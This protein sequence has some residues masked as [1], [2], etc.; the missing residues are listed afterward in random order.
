[1]IAILVGLG[2]VALSGYIWLTRGFF[3]A[4]IHLVCT[5]I[6]GAIAFALWEPI[7][8]A[9]LNSQS[10]SYGMVSSMAW[11]VSLLLPFLAS[12]AILRLVVDNILKWNVKVPQAV[13]YIGGG[14]C[15]A[16]AGA[17]IAGM[18][19]LSVGFL[20]VEREFMATPVGLE[21]SQS[22]GLE[23]KG[24][25]AIVD[26]F[27]VKFYSLLSRGA[28][29]TDT[30]LADLAP[31]LESL[32]TAM[33]MTDGDGKNSNAVKESEV[34]IKHRYT[35]D[36]KGKAKLDEIMSDKWR[37][38]ANLGPQRASDLSGNPYP[39]TSRI[40][41]FVVELG[42]GAV[43]KF[44]QI[45]ISNPQ[46]WLVCTTPDG[47][48]ERLHP[49]AVASAAQAVGTG[50]R[51]RF[52][53][54]HFDSKAGLHLASVGGGTSNPMA[55]EFLVPQG[56]E[57]RFVSVRNIRVDISGLKPVVF[58]SVAERDESIEAGTIFTGGQSVGGTID[59]ASLD[60]SQKITIG[61][62]RPLQPGQNVQIEGVQVTNTLGFTIQK[63]THGGL[64]LT[65]DN[66]IRGGRQNFAPDAFQQSGIIDRKLRVERFGGS[67]DAGIIQLDVSAT[68][69][70]NLLLRSV[71]NVETGEDRP[72]LVDS[73][74]R[75]YPAVGYVYQARDLVTVRFTPGSP[76]RSVANDIDTPLSLSR[77]DQKMRL[78]FRVSVG[79]EI[80]YFVVG[81]TIVADYN[82]GFKLEAAQR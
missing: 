27:T 28:F 17:I 73:Q 40:E 64:D 49:I 12:L 16:I 51:T 63:G 57:P 82:P 7:A 45:V 71:T 37:D 53:R 20:R 6:A 68:Q 54:F 62:G 55:F 72:M 22:G 24:N 30:A 42:S 21:W 18:I 11:G 15:G 52:G 9:I 79:A 39:V 58:G 38:A 4:F 67:E 13:N 2:I 14:L 25:G 10:T 80:R 50:G 41:G 43:E 74:G 26:K 75:T 81:K 3:S 69:Q 78:I 19:V 47:T 31:G 56:W 70:V 77:A 66:A 34:T 48:S 36:V 44:G 35:L 61:N 59:L 8:Y 23:A 33:R 5:I 32:P 60:A 29:S 1:M 65:D 46:V 76:I